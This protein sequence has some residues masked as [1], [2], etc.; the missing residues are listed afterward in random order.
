MIDRKLFSKSLQ[1]TA[2]GTG[3][4]AKQGVI[5]RRWEDWAF[6][7]EIYSGRQFRFFAKPVAWDY[8]LWD[9]LQ[10]E[11][12]KKKPATFHYWG[13]FTCNTPPV[14]ERAIKLGQ[15]ST[16]DLAQTLID[17][18]DQ[19]KNDHDWRKGMSFEQMRDLAS[20]EALKQ[21]YT[22]THVISLMSDQQYDAAKAL[23][24]QALNE[25]I[26]IRHVF[27]SFDKDDVPDSEGRRPSKSFFKLAEAYLRN[28]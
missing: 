15:L 28:V 6:S 19:S 11:G 24:R 23:C 14:C 21:D 2:K 27:S 26:Q 8:L 10:I 17:F 1:S 5:S 12:N 7:A 4:S 22:M 25:E 3:W 13:A 16:D 9:I 18:A 20:T